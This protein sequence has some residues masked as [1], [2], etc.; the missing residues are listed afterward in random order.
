MVIYYE[1]INGTNFGFRTTN[2]MS[3]DCTS[4]HQSFVLVAAIGT[5]NDDRHGRRRREDARNVRSLPVH[6][7]IYFFP[8]GSDNLVQ[9]FRQLF[10]ITEVDPTGR[11]S[12]AS[13]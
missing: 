8:S 10:G 6:L 11:W 9:L 3:A 4:R 5:G 12:S 7:F 13:P 1:H 2:R